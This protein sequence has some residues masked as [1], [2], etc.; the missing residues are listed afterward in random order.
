M[1][2][3]ELLGQNRHAR[4]EQ[5]VGGFF[6]SGRA[7]SG[8]PNLRWPLAQV[9][10]SCGGHLLSGLQRMATGL[11]K[12]F[13]VD[14][15]FGFIVPDNG[16]DDVFCHVRDLRGSGIS[17]LNEGDRVSY[18]PVPGREGKPKASKVALVR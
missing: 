18:E 7:S 11:V 12:F 16:G 10:R 15:G 6:I 14:R 3:A 2:L 1:R 17:S 5:S 9:S 4:P 8:K 13:S